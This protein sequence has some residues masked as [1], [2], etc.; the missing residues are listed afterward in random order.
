MRSK[1]IFLFLSGLIALLLPALVSCSD[2]QAKQMFLNEFDKMLGH[3]TTA[4]KLERVDL[5][6]T[7]NLIVYRPLLANDEKVAAYPY[8]VVFHVYRKSGDKVFDVKDIE[9]QTDKEGR[10]T[11]R[12]LF[13]RVYPSDEIFLEYRPPLFNWGFVDLDGRKGYSAKG[14]RRISYRDIKNARFDEKKNCFYLV[15]N[16]SGF[17]PPS[18]YR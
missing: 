15:V 17:I 4:E 12:T 14:E 16:D 13:S 9:E 7:V 1:V 18:S 8:S 11:L 5:D 3:T 2:K 10:V 6:L